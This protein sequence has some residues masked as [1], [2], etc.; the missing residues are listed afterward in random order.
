MGDMMRAGTV[1]VEMGWYHHVPLLM[2]FSGFPSLCLPFSWAS[3]LLHMGCSAFS[4][5]L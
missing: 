5:I 2:V 4:L 3:R 1:R